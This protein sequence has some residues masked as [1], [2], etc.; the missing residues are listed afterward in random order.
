MLHGHPPTD[1]ATGVD[2]APRLPESSTARATSV[3]ALSPD[4]CHGYVHGAR[5][6]GA[7]CQVVPP[8]SE[9]RPPPTTPPPVSAAVPLTVASWPRGNVVPATGATIVAE[10]AT[11]SVEAV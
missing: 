1:A 2:G 11:V 7:G 3:I 10:G 5:R 4:A 6:E 8:S 9:A